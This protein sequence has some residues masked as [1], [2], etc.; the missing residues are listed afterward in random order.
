MFSSVKSRNKARMSTLTTSLN[1]IPL[2]VQ[3]AQEFSCLENPL[4]GG[5]WVSYSARGRKRVRADL[6][7]NQDRPWAAD[8]WGSVLATG[9]EG[10]AAL[11]CSAER[12]PAAGPAASAGIT[13]V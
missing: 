9:L 7:T 11:P 4:D 10:R 1:T 13:G 8:H 6:T 2:N 5:A 12:L 3:L